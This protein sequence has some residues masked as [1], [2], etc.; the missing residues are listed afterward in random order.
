LTTDDGI[1]L[2]LLHRTAAAQSILVEGFRDGHGTYLTGEAQSGVFLSDVPVSLRE[3][4]TGADLLAVEVPEDVISEF[5]WV[6][7][8]GEEAGAASEADPDW[9]RWPEGA[10]WMPGRAR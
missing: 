8:S 9:S 5:E 2:V 4:A 1:R 7:L 6:D 10:P 3:G